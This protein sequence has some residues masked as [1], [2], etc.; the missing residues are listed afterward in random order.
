MSPKPK[1]KPIK[2]LNGNQ[3]NEKEKLRCAFYIA[4]IG[5]TITAIVVIFMILFN[6]RASADIVAVAG[7]FTSVTGT[8]VG[9]FVGAQISTEESDKTTSRLEEENKTLITQLENE[10]SKAENSYESLK[11]QYDSGLNLLDRTL[12]EIQDKKSI[13]EIN[14]A[15][16]KIYKMMS[17]TEFLKDPK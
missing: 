10:K 9:A 15:K 6:F 3:K 5:L 7:I 2:D 1:K 8:L 17:S 12:T 16:A 14:E 4:I 13:E 11:K